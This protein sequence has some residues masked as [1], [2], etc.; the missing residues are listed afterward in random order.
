VPA[1]S[2]DVEAPSACG[3]RY[4]QLG[5]EGHEGPLILDKIKKADIIVIATSIWFGVRSSIAQL[6]IERLDGTYSE[7]NERGQ[8]PLYN[9]VAGVVITGNEDGA[10]R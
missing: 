5:E 8:Y 1:C 4:E 7:R 2:I 9:K 6:V 10:Q 3:G